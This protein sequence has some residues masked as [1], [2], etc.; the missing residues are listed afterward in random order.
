MR[1]GVNPQSFAEAQPPW[2]S[3]RRVAVR[4]NRCANSPSRA[5]PRKMRKRNALPHTAEWAQIVWTLLVLEVFRDRRPCEHANPHQWVSGGLGAVLG[6]LVGGFVV[7]FTAGFSSRSCSDAKAMGHRPTLHLMSAI[8][9][10]GWAGAPRP[11]RFFIGRF[12]LVLSLY[13]FIPKE[14]RGLQ[15]GPLPEL[16]RRFFL[17]ITIA[18]SRPEWS[19]FSGLAIQCRN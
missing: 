12:A 10:G 14:A 17:M 4:M 19:G 15:F 1:S 16:R 9:R 18:Y 11:R 7:W 6:A 3:T 13:M 2:K 8:G 5:A